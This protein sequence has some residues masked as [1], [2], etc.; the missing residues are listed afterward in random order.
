MNYSMT[1]LGKLRA[2]SS[3]VI[4]Y[5]R[6]HSGH[7]YADFRRDKRFDPEVY[8]CLIQR[9]GSTEIL[10]WS[11]HRSLDRARIAA[12]IELKRLVDAEAL[13]TQTQA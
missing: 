7:F 12:E 2:N 3:Y 4:Q 10:S 5:E 9:E 13:R 6:L 11:Q 8:H 1:A